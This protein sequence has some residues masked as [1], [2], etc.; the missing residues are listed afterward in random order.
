METTNAIQGAVHPIET[1]EQISVD[2]LIEQRAGPGM[3][4]LAPPMRVLHIN[5]H[6]WDLISHLTH[7]KHGN[8]RSRHAMRPLPQ[9]IRQICAEIFYTLRD[10]NHAKDWEQFEIKRMLN[11]PNRTV[12]VRGFG[13][14]D[15]SGKG[16][17]R[18]VLLLEAIG[19]RKPE[20]N[21][22]TGLRFQL[23]TRE[24]AVVQCL[25]KGCSNKEISTALRIA[26][27]TVKEHIR[28]IMTKMDT[29]TRTGILVRIYH[30]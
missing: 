1:L 10:R 15:R 21:E 11:A 4:V 30:M 23:T 22:E 24:Q 28:H 6:A 5:Q 19:R 18:V 7:V 2:T 25:S 16:R 12:L 27:P 29:T 3:V 26:L 13:V 17:S 8:G 9:S 14:P 20:S